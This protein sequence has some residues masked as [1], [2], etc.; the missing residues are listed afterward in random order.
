MTIAD[1][2]VIAVILVLM[3]FAVRS[4]YKAKK[5]GGCCGDCAAAAAVT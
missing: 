4:M 2:I 5:K 1:I 3:A